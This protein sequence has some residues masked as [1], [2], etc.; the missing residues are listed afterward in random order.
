METNTI[1][2]FDPIWRRP[3]VLEATGIATSTLYAAMKAG[4]FPKPIRLGPN[5]VGWRRSAIEA[6][7]AER[8]AA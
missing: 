1:Q 7:I 2:N 3:K 6:W 5:S 8:E 4:T